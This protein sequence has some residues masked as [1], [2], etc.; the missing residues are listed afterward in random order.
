MAAPVYK[1]DAA[2][3]MS[4]RADLWECIDD[5]RS[6]IPHEMYTSLRSAMVKVDQACIPNVPISRAGSRVGMGLNKAQKNIACDNIISIVKQIK[7]LK[8]W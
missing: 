4:E 8:A 5:L 2:I 3:A 6:V 1:P 7:A